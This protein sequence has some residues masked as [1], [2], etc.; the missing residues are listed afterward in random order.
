MGMTTRAGWVG[1]L[2]G[3]LITLILYPFFLAWYP[4]LLTGEHMVSMRL[5][6]IAVV[7]MFF[8]F[9]G[10][11]FVAAKW[12]GSVQVGRCVAFAAPAG[13]LAGMLVFSLWGAAAAGLVQW[14][15][16][17][18]SPPLA[19]PYPISQIELIGLI[20]HQTLGMFLILF[21]GGS[22]SGSIPRM[23]S[24]ARNKSWPW[25]KD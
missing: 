23:A 10:G 21:L 22:A 25:P 15:N 18:T 5:G 2:T 3:L 9:I 12:S 1:V 4:A 7:L 16:S 13:G 11:G 8:I 19:I 24:M 6:W 17:F 14:G 20:I